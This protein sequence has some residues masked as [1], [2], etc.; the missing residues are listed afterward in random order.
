MVCYK[1][2]DWPMNELTDC[3]NAQDERKVRIMD[4]DEQE[5][6]I[7]DI[8]EQELSIMTSMNRKGE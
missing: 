6:R 8:D 4:M 3:A 1:L 7:M 5:W 2:S